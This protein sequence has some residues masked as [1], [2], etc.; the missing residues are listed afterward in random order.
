MEPRLFSTGPSSSLATGKERVG[1]ER[2]GKERVGKERV[3]KERVGKER[4]GKERVGKERVGKERVGRNE[5]GRNELGRN[6]SPFL[7]VHRAGSTVV[8]CR[9]AGG[10]QARCRFPS[11][12][13]TAAAAV[14]S[15]QFK[16]PWSLQGSLEDE[17][18]ENFIPFVTRSKTV[19]RYKAEAESRLRSSPAVEE[20]ACSTDPMNQVQQAGPHW[21]EMYEEAPPRLLSGQAALRPNAKQDIRRPTSARKLERLPSPRELYGKGKGRRRAAGERRV[22]AVIYHLEELKRRQSDI[23]Q[24]KALKWGMSRSQCLTSDDEEPVI[25]NPDQQPTHSTSIVDFTNNTDLEDRELFFQ[26]RWNV[27]FLEQRLA[28]PDAPYTAYYKTEAEE[29]HQPFQFLMEP[30]QEDS[31]FWDVNYRSEE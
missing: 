2:V 14:M 30:V 12:G 15:Q 18:V 9:T 5:L 3:G 23:D 19:S 16:T 27:G 22:M 26:P 20:W 31:G 29:N 24:L 28:Q 4:V 25:V 6:E 8:V 17:D 1:K 11:G 21:M 10:S 7:A 13:P